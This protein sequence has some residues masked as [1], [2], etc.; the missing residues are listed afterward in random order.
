MLLKVLVINP[1]LTSPFLTSPWDRA[2]QLSKE[3]DWENKYK[4]SLMSLNP[5]FKPIN[6]TS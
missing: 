2:S 4:M 3:R 5:M 6:P 1:F